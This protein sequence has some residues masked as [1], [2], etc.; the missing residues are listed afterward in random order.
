MQPAGR[1][2]QVERAEFSGVI[3]IDQ[4]GLGFRE[5]QI[6]A[7]ITPPI[8]LEHGQ[9]KRLGVAR[10]QQRLRERREA[11]L[12]NAQSPI[13][14][15][16][17]FV[18]G[19]DPVER[20]ARLAGGRIAAVVKIQRRFSNSLIRIL[21]DSLASGNLFCKT[22][23]RRGQQQFA[24]VRLLLGGERPHDR[25]RLRQC[26]VSN[27]NPPVLV[28]AG[29]TCGCKIDEN[30]DQPRPCMFGET[31]GRQKAVNIDNASIG[32]A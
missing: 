22:G 31:A 26:I 3:G 25:S 23:Q 24:G 11:N 15:P 19:Q 8:R 32:E 27:K 18:V 14:R 28:A 9:Q 30:V 21:S 6:G 12:E 1:H 10:R 5:R 29:E 20:V 17:S 13:L 2:D 16:E 4:P 7:F